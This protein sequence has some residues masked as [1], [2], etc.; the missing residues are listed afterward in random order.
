M[1]ASCTAQ[2]SGPCWFCL[3]SPQVEKHLVIS[4]GTH[5]SVKVGKWASFQEGW[6]LWRLFAVLPGDGEGRPDS[7][8]RADPAHRPLPVRGGSEL[9]GGAGDGE[10][11]VGPEELLQEPGRALHPVWEELQKPAPAAPGRTRSHQ[12]IKTLLLKVTVLVLTA[13]FTRV[14][15]TNTYLTVYLNF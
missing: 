10:V 5:V 14:F 3:A 7:S 2:P 13:L 11:Q 8:P 1:F 9:R 6:R 4:I 12:P 15:C